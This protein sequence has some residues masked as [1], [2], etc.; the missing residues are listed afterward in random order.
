MACAGS[1]RMREAGLSLVEVMVA[2]VVGLITVLVVAQVFSAFE[3]DKRTTMGASDAQTG[4]ALALYTLRRQLVAAGYGLPVFTTQNN[5]LQQCPTDCTVGGNS[6]PCAQG[7]PLGGNGVSLFPVEIVDGGTGSDTI[8]VRFGTSPL[9]GVHSTVQNATG[10][11]LTVDNNQACTLGDNVLLM[12]PPNGCFVAAVTGLPAAP[13]TTNVTVSGAVAALGAFVDPNRTVLACLGTWTQLT[14]A[15]NNERLEVATAANGVT[16]TSP[17]IPDIVNL[18]AQYGISAAANDNVIRE[19]VDA[20]G[21]WANLNDEAAD[22][23]RRNRIKAVRIAVVARSG[24]LERDNV[25]AACD[26]STAPPTGLCAWADVPAGGAITTASPAPAIN[27][28]PN[29]ANPDWQRYRYRVFET[30]IP[31]RNLIWNRT[32]L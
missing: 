9:A 11:V 6:G 25:T 14:Y 26:Q 29:N 20:T 30:I 19:W 7:A 31:L 16:T 1:H 21:V 28:N 17:A 32:S 12:T 10:N 15:V 24:V 27:L 13:A 2:L 23:A 22:V 3:G 4:G 18:Q 5:V 8:R